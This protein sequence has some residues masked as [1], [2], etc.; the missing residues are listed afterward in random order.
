MSKLWLSVLR[1][2]GLVGLLWATCQ[3]MAGDI[4]IDAAPPPSEIASALP[5][6][7]LQGR[8]TM[9]LFGL[10]IYEVRLWAV[11]GFTS[12]RYDTQSFALELRYARR[13]DGA[14]IVERSIAEMRHAGPVDDMQARVWQAAMTRAFPDV[15]AGDR[16]TGIN[17]ADGTT[18]FFHNARSTASVSDPEFARRFFGIWLAQ[19]TSEP[20][21]RRRLIG[22][23]P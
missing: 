3:V 21:L 22:Q 12:E 18:R 1:G 20:A 2:S 10:A 5:A 7:T 14:A 15:I 13:L 17:Q 16:L 11:T 23:A 8:A 4:P 6:A 9:R 19:T